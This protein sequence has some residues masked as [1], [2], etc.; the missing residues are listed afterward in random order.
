MFLSKIMKSL[1]IFLLVLT[2]NLILAQDSY[3]ILGRGFVDE[4]VQIKATKDVLFEGKV[5]SSLEYG[6]AKIIKLNEDNKHLVLIAIDEGLEVFV[7]LSRFNH[8]LS[9]RISYSSFVAREEKR[10]I[11][12]VEPVKTKWVKKLPDF[13]WEW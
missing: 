8:R 3:L 6:V 9:I 5:V 4:K 12:I 7:D 13:L 11:V 10:R 2:N 1:I